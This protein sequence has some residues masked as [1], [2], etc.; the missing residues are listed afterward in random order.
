MW[1]VQ[2]FEEYLER[3]PV[4]RRNA[5]R[6]LEAR[7]REL[8]ERF[9]D[10]STE[11]VAPRLRNEL[12]R[13]SDLFARPVNGHRE[14]QLS[15]RELAQLTATTLSTVSRLLGQWERMGIVSVKRGAVQLCDLTALKQLTL[16]D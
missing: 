11:K 9:L 5:V 12:I 8:E 16:S 14:I 2:R 15:Q 1:G 10:V 6:L 4:F 7:L 13:L 3:F